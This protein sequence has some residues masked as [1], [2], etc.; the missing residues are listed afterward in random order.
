VNIQTV[1]CVNRRCAYNVNGE[2]GVKLSHE[3]Q[4]YEIGFCEN[5]FR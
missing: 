4:F 1:T 5:V 2:S 3:M